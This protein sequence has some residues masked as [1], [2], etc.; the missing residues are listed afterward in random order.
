M[1]LNYRLQA[2]NAK[3]VSFLRIISSLHEALLS[4][5]DGTSSMK[6][7]QAAKDAD[8]HEVSHPA[9]EE[10]KKDAHE[11]DAKESEHNEDGGK[12]WDNGATYIEEEPWPGD[13]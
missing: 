9:E 8:Q 1:D 2:T 10:W 6:D 5:S 12:K 4:E 11:E 3:V 7:S 13:L